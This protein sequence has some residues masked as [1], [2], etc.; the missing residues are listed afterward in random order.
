MQSSVATSSASARFEQGAKSLICENKKGQQLS[1]AVCR[2]QAARAANGQCFNATQS[3][4]AQRRLTVS[5][6]VN[7][8]VRIFSLRPLCRLESQGGRQTTSGQWECEPCAS[9]LAY[10][11]WA[12]EEIIS[13]ALFS[14]RNLRIRCPQVCSLVSFCF[15]LSA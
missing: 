13:S 8:C 15:V 1:V 12:D 14:L 5:R 10:F 6:C 7:L 9:Q 4:S 3:C 2:R 11:H